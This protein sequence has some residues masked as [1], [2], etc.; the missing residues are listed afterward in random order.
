MVTLVW[1][2]SALVIPR[3][4]QGLT[5]QEAVGLC[6]KWIH[7]IK[8]RLWQKIGTIAMLPATVHCEALLLTVVDVERG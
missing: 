2:L 1:S 6:W 3:P 8:R 7:S 5:Q 4:L